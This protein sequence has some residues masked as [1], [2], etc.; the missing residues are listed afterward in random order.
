MKSAGFESAI[1]KIKRLQ[2]YA[3][4]LTTTGVYERNIGNTVPSDF[5]VISD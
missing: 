1:S 4:D 3:L 2:T 5:T